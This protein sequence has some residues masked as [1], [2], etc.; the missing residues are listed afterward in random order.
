MVPT[1]LKLVPYDHPGLRKKTS[2]VNF[3]LSSEDQ[4]IIASML[5]SIQKKQLLAANASFE[6]AAGMAAN[7]WGIDRS[8]FLFCPEGN[9]RGNVEVII[10]PSYAELSPQQDEAWEGCFSVPNASGKVKRYLRIKVKY[11]NVAGEW[12]EQ[13]LSDWYARVWQHETDH[14]NGCLYD[15]HTA[16]KCLEKVT[17]NNEAEL[18]IFYNRMRSEHN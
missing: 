16:G 11:Q 15:D 2:K 6:S 1:L 5:F 14:L 7:Q 10:N 12:L 17:F 3:P 4:Q 8:I 9:E 18:E 13:E